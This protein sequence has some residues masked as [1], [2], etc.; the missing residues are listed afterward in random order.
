[1]NGAEAFSVAFE[2]EDRLVESVSSAMVLSCGS[3]AAFTMVRAVRCEF[4]QM[5]VEQFV[6]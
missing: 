6:Y 1:L 2:D 3:M 5:R 4:P